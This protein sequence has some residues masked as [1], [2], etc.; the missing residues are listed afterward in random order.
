MSSSFQRR[1]RSRRTHPKPK[2]QRR[3][4]ME[5]LE[6]RHLLAGVSE[7]VSSSATES[8]AT[9]VGIHIAGEIGELARTASLPTP[10]L[11]WTPQDDGTSFGDTTDAVRW[12]AIEGERFGNFTLRF[13]FTLAQ[14]AMDDLN[15]PT[16]FAHRI[17]SKSG[18]DASGF[19]VGI[20][21]ETRT[22]FI[23]WTFKEKWPKV[24]SNTVVETGVP[25]VLLVEREGANIRFV[26]N[27]ENAGGGSFPQANIVQKGEYA[28]YIGALFNK[29]A[30]LVQPMKGELVHIGLYGI[31]S[32]E[33]LE[34]LA[35]ARI[36][37]GYSTIE[38]SN[39][40]PA[41]DD[42]PG[43]ADPQLIVE[44]TEL[45]IASAAMTRATVQIPVPSKVEGLGENENKVRLFNE[46]ISLQDGPLTFSGGF[47]G[48]NYDVF[49]TEFRSNGATVITFGSAM[50]YNSM[51]LTTYTPTRE[52][53]RRDVDLGG[54][55]HFFSLTVSPEDVLFTVDGNELLLPVGIESIDEIIVSG[56]YNVNLEAAS[57]THE[58]LVESSTS[59]RDWEE[60]V[61][62]AIDDIA[63]GTVDLV[64]FEYA[65]IER[66]HRNTETR[67]PLETLGGEAVLKS[68]QGTTRMEAVISST[69]SLGIRSNGSALTIGLRTTALVES[70]SF[71]IDTD[72]HAHDIDVQAYRSGKL[73]ASRIAAPGSTVEF[74]DEG[75]ID[76]IIV[77]NPIKTS[78]DVDDETDSL[79][80]SN[81]FVGGWHAEQE[82]AATPSPAT[83]A[84][85]SLL[86][87]P[88]VPAIPRDVYA[89]KIG[90]P[91]DYRNQALRAVHAQCIADEY[92]SYVVN[93][94][95]VE[96]IRSKQL[97]YLDHEGTYHLLP[98]EMYQWA[99]AT[100]ILFPGAPEFVAFDMYQNGYT[101]A[102]ELGTHAATL[103][104][105]LPRPGVDIRHGIT[106]VRPGFHDEGF[107]EPYAIRGERSAVGGNVNVVVQLNNYGSGGGH[108]IVD[109]FMGDDLQ[110]SF[111][112]EDDLGRP[113]RSGEELFLSVNVRGTAGEQIRIVVTDEDGDEVQ[114]S[115]R[116]RL[117]RERSDRKPPTPSGVEM[118]SE[119]EI[120][121]TIRIF[122]EA[123]QK[124]V[125]PR[126]TVQVQSK[127]G[128]ET[129]QSLPVYAYYLSRPVDWWLLKQSQSHNFIV[130]DARFIGD[131]DALVHSYG[132]TEAGTL[133]RVTENTTG[134]SEDTHQSDWDAWRS[135]GM[136][137]P[138]IGVYAT[139]IPASS[140]DVRK[141]AFS[142]IADVDYAA[143]AGSFGAN[144]N[145]AAQAI[146]NAATCQISPPPDGD[147]NSQGWENASDIHFVIDHHCR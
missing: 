65:R 103:D 24:L 76:A 64:D 23:S 147:R 101:N 123:G 143:V 110:R 79:I 69:G 26:L 29:T 52:D 72:S 55:T 74:V 126:V 18:K 121:G 107:S 86:V 93:M 105:L 85:L 140:E 53:V 137:T 17:Q 116:T 11:E 22:P 145:S 70:M 132:L 139:L 127:V 4:T 122:A 33:E 114:S 49:A 94:S 68:W 41:T 82:L 25:Y 119:G 108:C 88:K 56:R 9:E 78:T 104:E 77:P 117:H 92:V 28:S 133:G 59:G 60:A 48:E 71:F 51:S 12:E 84:D 57:L 20:D 37:E 36:E 7:G 27:G 15:F 32:Q 100:V 30:G 2:H 47:T 1:P 83:I 120:S 54:G 130:T 80:L 44:E 16:L 131:P 138:Q 13:E 34:A 87:A 62:A 75:G 135:L 63:H 46:H 50:T 129:V 58:R 99:G 118:E 38:D 91:G 90:G 3:P 134:F 112:T 115:R 45:T 43:E 21:A 67:L 113:V 81:L 98:E 8:S 111:N 40:V 5:R 14:G 124:D 10:K 66:D 42:L 6:P 35:S 73:I 96:Q 109:V 61:D 106:A 95:G 141:L 89:P 144:S 97:F 128:Q 136:G 39:R 102:F 125:E 31:L 142:L 146:V 19:V